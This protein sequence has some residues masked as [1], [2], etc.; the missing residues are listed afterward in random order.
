MRHNSYC[1]ARKAEI[2]KLRKLA[3]LDFV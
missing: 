1:A 3:L 2:I